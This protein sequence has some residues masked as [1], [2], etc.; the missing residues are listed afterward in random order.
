MPKTA[1]GTLIAT[2]NI[3]SRDRGLGATNEASADAR[4]PKLCSFGNKQTI[5]ALGDTG[6]DV[7]LISHSLFTSIPD[8]YKS[9]FNKLV[10]IALASVIGHSLYVYGKCNLTF[11]FGKKI[12]ILFIHYRKEN[13]TWFNFG[14]RFLTNVDVKWDFSQCS[15]S[16]GST[17][18]VLMDKQKP[19]RETVNL[20]QVKLSCVIPPKLSTVILCVLPKA[21]RRE[22]I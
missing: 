9:K 16:I 21:R 19:K 13:A 6:A 18:V 5:D 22:Y 3:I 14:K 4:L 10:S 11:T 2:S 15:L 12:S 8:K 1:F 17:V 7:S 20:V